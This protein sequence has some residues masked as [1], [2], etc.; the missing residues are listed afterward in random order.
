MCSP[1]L[2]LCQLTQENADRTIKSKL[3]LAD[4]AGSEDNRRAQVS[5]QKLEETTLPQLLQPSA[6]PT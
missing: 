3:C 2:L 6:A 1:E 5:G 4:L